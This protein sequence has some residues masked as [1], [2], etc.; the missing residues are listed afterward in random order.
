VTVRK[1]PQRPA[2]DQQPDPAPAARAAEGPQLAGGH[3]SC[4]DADA[5]CLAELLAEARGMWR[6]MEGRN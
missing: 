5:P 3:A 4:R 2:R 1:R 6:E